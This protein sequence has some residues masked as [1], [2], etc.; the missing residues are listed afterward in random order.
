MMKEGRTWDIR[1]G[2]NF[3]NTEAGHF[4]PDDGG[5]EELFL[6]LSWTKPAHKHMKK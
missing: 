4:V 6:Q 3:T 5:E 1:A 2:S